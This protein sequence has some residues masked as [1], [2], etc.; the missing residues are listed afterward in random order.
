MFILFKI[1]GTEFCVR[2]EMFQPEN[3]N[4]GNANSGGHH[5][6]HVCDVYSTKAPSLAMTSKRRWP[7]EYTVF[8]LKWWRCVTALTR[9]KYKIIHIVQCAYKWLKHT[10]IFILG[11]FIAEI[12][13][14]VI[15]VAVLISS[16]C[17]RLHQG[18]LNEQSQCWSRYYFLMMYVRWCKY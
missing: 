4:G 8:N 5:S 12:L 3:Y 14:P 2:G 15:N 18:P 7:L 16:S 10:L 1:S 17:P 9:D 11:Y 13:T 6:I